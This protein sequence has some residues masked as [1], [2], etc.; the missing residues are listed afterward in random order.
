MRGRSLQKKVPPSG[1]VKIII[2][3]KASSSHLQMYLQYENDLGG[4]TTLVFF[5]CVRQ[6]LSKMV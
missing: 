6:E 3:K 2:S 1:K 4:Q 5:K